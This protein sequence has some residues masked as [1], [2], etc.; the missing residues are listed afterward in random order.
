M[1]PFARARL[2]VIFPHRMVNSIV[3]MI[4]L[5]MVKLMVKL[6]ENFEIL[7]EQQPPQGSSSVIMLVL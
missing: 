4:F 6:W 1:R 2:G 5:L 3:K 7:A